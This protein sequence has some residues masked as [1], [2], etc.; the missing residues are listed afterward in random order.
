MLMTFEKLHDSN[1]YELPP[2]DPDTLKKVIEVTD[3]TIYSQMNTQGNKTEFK[4]NGEGNVEEMRIIDKD[5]QIIFYQDIEGIRAFRN[6]YKS[7]K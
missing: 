4:L 3:P 2:I 7:F 5:G 6:K 1:Q